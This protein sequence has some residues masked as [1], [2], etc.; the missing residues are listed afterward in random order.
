MEA[1]P[2]LRQIK[3]LKKLNK[4]VRRILK[5][6]GSFNEIGVWRNRKNFKIKYLFQDIKL[7]LILL[8]RSRQVQR[9]QDQ[10]KMQGFNGRRSQ[11]I[12][13]KSWEYVRDNANQLLGIS[14]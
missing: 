9:I 13:R 5:S 1:R 7:G 3:L 8:L 11:E 4:F 12:S 2:G 14:N 10:K 6:F